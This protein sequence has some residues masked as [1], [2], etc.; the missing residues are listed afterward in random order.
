MD[1]CSEEYI[2]LYDVQNYT[3][4]TALIKTAIACKSWIFFARGI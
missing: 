4:Y 1:L 2:K 3:K